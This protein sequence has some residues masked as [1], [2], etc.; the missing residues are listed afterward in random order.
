MRQGSKEYSILMICE[1]LP[2]NQPVFVKSVG[3][4]VVESAAPLVLL[5]YVQHYA[6]VHRHG[7]VLLP[8]TVTHK[9]T[10][11]RHRWYR[12]V[13]LYFIFSSLQHR[14][15]LYVFENEYAYKILLFKT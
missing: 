14:D 6:A 10:N 9:Q 1:Q 11:K 7:A 13:M 5:L 2:T 15:S 8:A 4:F 12:A 3:V